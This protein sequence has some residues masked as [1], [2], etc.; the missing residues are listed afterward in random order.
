MKPR[1]I[2]PEAREAPPVAR[3]LLD[4]HV[5]VWYLDGAEDRLASAAIDTIRGALRRDGV[6]VSDI[7]VW[8][9]GT[10]SAKGKITLTPTVH[11]WIERASRRPGFSFMALDRDILLSST[12]LPGLS[13]GDPADRMLIASAALAGVLLATADPQIIAYAEAQGGFSVLDVRP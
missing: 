10:K 7:S 6:L 8:E 1:K 13:H 11:A 3:I 4:T 2:R 12:Q 5:W 9:L